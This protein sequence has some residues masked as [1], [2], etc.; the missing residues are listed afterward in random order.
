MSDESEGESDLEALSVNHL[1][2][3]S[4]QICWNRLGIRCALQVFFAGI[5][6]CKIRITNNE[7]GY[8]M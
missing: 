1:E 3:D 5:L 4:C 2:C 8:T 7:T 6:K